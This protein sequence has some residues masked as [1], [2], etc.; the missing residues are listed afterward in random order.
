M[1]TTGRFYRTPDAEFPEPSAPVASDPF[2]DTVRA[3]Q[4][5]L[6]AFGYY[7]GPINGVIDADMQYALT[8]FQGD[9]GLRVTG[10]ITPDVLKALNIRF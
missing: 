10:T 7:R 9:Y 4:R 5:G 6:A 2:L 3:V 8:R 1:S